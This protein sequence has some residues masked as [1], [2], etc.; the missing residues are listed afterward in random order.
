AKVIVG[1]QTPTGSGYFVRVDGDPKVYS[2]AS[3]NKSSIDKTAN[4][5]RDKRLLTFDSD[6]LTR[7]ELNA[8]KSSLEFGKNS[9]NEWQIV[10]PKPLRAD[11]LQVDEIVRKLR[12]AKMD[13]AVSEDDAKKAGAEF[14]SS[15][16]VATAKV[17]DAS[18]TQTLD[19]KKK[20][21]TYYARSSV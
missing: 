6:K 15:E 7:V 12:E 18:G 4:D 5:L 11:N 1:D 21:D 20:G 19:V 2:I 16:T 9:Q 13:P 17:T 8:K 14:A 10:K 3:F